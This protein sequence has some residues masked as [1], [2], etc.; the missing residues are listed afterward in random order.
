MGTYALVGL[1]LTVFPPLGQVLSD[2]RKVVDNLFLPMPI[3]IAWGV[4]LFLVGGALL[5]G[6]RAGWWIAVIGMALL[7]LYNAFLWWYTVTGATSNIKIPEITERLLTAST[8]T[9]ALLLIAFIVASP[10]FPAHTRPGSVWRALVMWGFGTLAVFLVGLGLVYLFP[11]SLLNSDRF[12]YVLNHA[13]T[14]SLIDP[15][16]FQGHAPRL[17]GFLISTGSGSVIV[18][19]V[20]LML[21]SKTNEAG[22]SSV[23]E[24]II[25]GMIDRFNRDDSLAYFATRRDK[26]IVYAPNGRAAVT[27]RVEAG[28][29]LASADPI[30]DPD[31]WGD[32]IEAWIARSREFGWAPGVMGASERGAHAYRKHGLSVIRLGDEAVLYPRDFRLGAPE[33]RAVR[34]SVTHARREGVTVRVRRHS[35]LSSEEL[36]DVERRANLWRDSTDERGFSMALSRIG[37]PNDGDCVLVEALMGEEVVAELSFVPWGKNGISLDLMRRS[38]G[39]PNGTIEA[40]I[41]ELCT[42]D[43]LG[44]SRI[45]LNFAVFRQIFATE[46]ELGIAPWTRAARKVLVFFSRWWQ[47]ETLY[48]SNEKYSPEWVPRYMGFAESAVLVRTAIAGGIAE[49]FVPVLA[50]TNL[51]HTSRVLDTTDGAKAAFEQLDQWQEET[52]QGAAG[53]RRISEQVGVRIAAAQRMQASGIDPWPEAVRPTVGCKDVITLHSNTRVTVSGRVLARRRFGGVVFLKL[54]DFDGQCQVVLERRSSPTGED[55]AADV[56]LA[57]LVQVTGVT[58]KSRN[59]TPSVIATGL[60]VEAKALQPLPDKRHGL[61]D[62]ELRLRSRHLDMV[63]NPTIRKGLHTRSKVLHAFRTVLHE[64]GFLE[65]ETPIL[66]QVHGGANARP[67]LTHI[68][69]YN[70]DLY[71]RIAPELYLKRLM[72]GGAEKIFELGRDFRN[73][74]VDASHNPEFTVLEAYEAHGDYRSMMQMARKLIQ[75]AATEV[76]GRPLVRDPRNPEAAPVDISGAWPVRSVLDAVSEELTRVVREKN[77]NEPG[78]RVTV[79]SS[80]QTLRTYCDVVGTDWMASWDQGKLIEELYSDLVEATTETPTFYCD[81][82]KSVSPLARESK[83]NPGLTERWD[84]V[85]FGMELGTAYSELTNPLEQRRRLEE[86]SLQAAG[87]DAEAMEVDEDFLRALEFGMPPTGGLGLGVDRIIMLIGG[88]TMRDVLAFPLARP[89][90]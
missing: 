27:Y 57:D 14:L 80:V 17:V 86:Q 40:M 2:A 31:A 54:Q 81:F 22:L 9:Q 19:A 55:L 53:K 38:H 74:G 60:R 85:A 8:I 65:V 36:K 18:G 90:D 50:P 72:C 56:D 34:Q 49:G 30:G 48:R 13:V 89:R 68:N 78:I 42:N 88:G 51:V 63:V 29:S 16:Q 20:W 77:P 52:S 44:I 75:R 41:T 24:Q 87:G 35:Q 64:R 46:D 83:K 43:S 61:Q 67:F 12:G 58:G 69:A 15:A 47:M 26:S 79:N 7:N 23:D 10:A 1:I 21:R 62:P 25:R 37:D 32:A 66:Q 4:A 59:G 33:M 71:L 39:S 6:K 3:S 5:A 73:E 45:S 82:P 84:L 70:M 11:G 28:V 76:H